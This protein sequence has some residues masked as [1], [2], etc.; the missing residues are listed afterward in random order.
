MSRVSGPPITE[1][2]SAASETVRVSGRTC[3]RRLNGEAVWGATRPKLGLMPN[4]PVKAAGMRIEPA[5]SVPMWRGPRVSS[6]AGGAAP[7]EPAGGEGPECERRGACRAAGRAARRAVELPRVARDAGKRRVANADP[8]E[9]GQ[10]G[11]AENDGTAL[12][13]PR[14]RRRII[15]HRRLASGERDAPRGRALEPD[16]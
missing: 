1:S 8:A 12:A 3:A 13:Q 5:P 4:T 6:A 11:L 10:R 2:I 7:R 9:L 14:D 15:L 16:I